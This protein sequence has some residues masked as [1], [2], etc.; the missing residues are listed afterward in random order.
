MCVTVMVS[1]EEIDR[2]S[3]THFHHIERHSEHWQHR[4]RLTTMRK[5]VGEVVA[6]YVSVRDETCVSTKEE[7][8]AIVSRW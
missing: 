8:Y 1:Y 7:S 3:A 5:I 2:L 4:S 6:E